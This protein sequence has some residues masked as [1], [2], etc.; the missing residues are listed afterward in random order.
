MQ[1][2]AKTASHEPDNQQSTR[3]ATWA[4]RFGTSGFIKENN[5]A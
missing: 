1:T 2:I 3:M 4:I 5:I